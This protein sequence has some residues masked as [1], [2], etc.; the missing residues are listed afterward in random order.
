MVVK[1]PD[2]YLTSAR[3]TT[4]PVCRKLHMQQQ[5]EVQQRFAK[6]MFTIWSDLQFE[7]R[8]CA[9]TIRYIKIKLIQ[10]LEYQLTEFLGISVN[11]FSVCV[12][13]FAKCLVHLLLAKAINTFIP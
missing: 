9:E 10:L 11:R 2:Q 6:Q 7:H 5:V 3:K 1:I 13:L 12:E 4:D 8:I